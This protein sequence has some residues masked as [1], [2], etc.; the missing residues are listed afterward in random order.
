MSWYF[1]PRDAP[2]IT[3][4]LN[5]HQRP[6]DDPDRRYDTWPFCAFLQERF[7]HNFV[8]QMWN[9]ARQN[10]PPSRCAGWDFGPGLTPQLKSLAGDT[11][12]WQRY[13]AVTRRSDGRWTSAGCNLCWL[14]FEVVNLQPML[15]NAGRHPQ[16]LTINFQATPFP[17]DW[18]AV[19]VLVEGDGRR[20]DDGPSRPSYTFS[21][22]VVA[23]H[24][25][26]GGVIRQ[27]DLLG[28]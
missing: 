24:D 9:E 7:G 26:C 25:Q 13:N 28:W 2:P 19:V 6:L 5:A 12:G 21:T 3:G 1:H 11:N 18:R 14:G 15:D 10:E 8:G 27:A 4:W 22:Q 17:E 23:G 20:H 16:T